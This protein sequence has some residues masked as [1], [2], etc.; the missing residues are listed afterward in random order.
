MI[1]VLLINSMVVSEQRREAQDARRRNGGWT[2]PYVNYLAAPQSRGTGEASLF[3]RW[4]GRSRQ[5]RAPADF[6]AAL[7]RR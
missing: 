2:E 6:I 3:V 7:T 1:D 5:H 4:L